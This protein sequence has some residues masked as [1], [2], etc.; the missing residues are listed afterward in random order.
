M[1][2]MTTG[3]PFRLVFE[4]DLYQYDWAKVE[5]TASALR[6][7]LEAEYSRHTFEIIGASLRASRRA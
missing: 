3:G 5:A 1:S 6:Q 4:I 7:V 2:E